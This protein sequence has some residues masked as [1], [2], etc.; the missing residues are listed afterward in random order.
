MQNHLTDTFPVGILKMG[1]LGE[2]P[3]SQRS[4]LYPNMNIFLVSMV[5]ASHGMIHTQRQGQIVRIKTQVL[6]KWIFVTC[7]SLWGSQNT[8]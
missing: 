3:Y 5:Y 7:Q 4:F 6:M 8:A 2:F 1:L